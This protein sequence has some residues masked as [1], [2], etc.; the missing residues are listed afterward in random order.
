VDEQLL[1]GQGKRSDDAMQD[2]LTLHAI[3]VFALSSRFPNPY[4]CF[5]HRRPRT[6]NDLV[7]MSDKLRHGF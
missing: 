3:F 2:T 5:V 7:I 1:I 6:P 4:E